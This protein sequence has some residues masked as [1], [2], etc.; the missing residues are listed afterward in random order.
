MLD[1][2]PD[3]IQLARVKKG[4]YQFV[5]EVINKVRI[6]VWKNNLHFSIFI[7]ETL[8]LLILIFLSGVRPVKTFISPLS[9][10]KPLTQDKSQKEVFGFAPYWTFDKLDNVNFDVLTTLAYFSIPV[11]DYGNLDTND[12]GYYTF[13]SDK[14]TETFKKAHDNG[15]RVVLTL[16]Q[17]ENWPILALL[18]NPD[19][20]ENAINQSVNLVKE[21][22]IDG[23]NVDFEY[24]GD[25]GDYYRE[26]FSQFVLNLTQKMHQEVGGSKVT[27]SVYAASVK[28]P[29]LYDIASLSKNSDGIFM[30]AYD[31]ALPN[32]DN[33]M[34]T[35]P[36]YGYKEGLYWYDVSTAVDDFLSYMPASKLILGVPWYAYNYVVYEPSVKA[37]TVGRSVT[38]T[39]SAIQDNINPNMSDIVNYKSGWDNVGKVSWKAYLRASSGAWRMVFLDD[40]RSLTEKFDFVKSKNLLG[41]GMWALGFDDGKSEFWAL[42]ENKFGTKL[43][44]K[45]IDNNDNI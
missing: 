11:D 16:T 44:N 32:S 23:V 5:N 10:L 21:R 31:F 45:K 38:Q 1:F 15:T 24:Q 27:V 7:F 19:A 13:K 30:M 4:I 29:K 36:L 8:F 6:Y 25:P 22:G 28:D 37:E 9:H 18:D 40:V 34:P 43:A 41:V 14:A 3:K 12:Q 42:L 35:A 39:Y 2:L 17:M 26:K 33:A 20:W